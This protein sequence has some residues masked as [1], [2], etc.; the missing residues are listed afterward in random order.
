MQM[1]VLLLQENQIKEAD[2][3]YAKK[4]DNQIGKGKINRFL[5]IHNIITFCWWKET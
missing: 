4:D 5:S 1:S 2:K 3:L